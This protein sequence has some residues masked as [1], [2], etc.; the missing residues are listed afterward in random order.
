MP[1]FFFDVVLD[2]VTE[3]DDR[4]LDL[5]SVLVARAEASRAAI[6]MV[7][8]GAAGEDAAVAIIARDETGKPLFK[9]SALVRVDPADETDGPAPE[10]RLRSRH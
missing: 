10:R 9:V 2:G 8:E 5:S 3:A 7:K 4:G 6:E 1:R